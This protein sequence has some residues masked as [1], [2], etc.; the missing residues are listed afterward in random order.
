M[1]CWTIHL[2]V[3][4]KLNENYKL[5]KDRF[6]Y[7]SILPDVAST[8]VYGRD[9]SH[10]FGSKM[11]DACPEEVIVDI[12]KFKSVYQENL[13]KELILGYYVHMLT[14]YFY[15][16]YVFRNF[17]IKD[18]NDHI[19]GLRTKEGDLLIPNP[20]DTKGRRKYK[21]RDFVNYGK[22][23]LEN[24][25]IEIPTSL[26]EIK[27]ELDLLNNHFLGEEE[28]KERLDYLSS[29]EFIEFN[30]GYHDDLFVL[31]KKDEYQKLFDECVEFCRNE[32]KKYIKI[33]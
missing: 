24:G 21:Q 15:N 8:N 19:I 33:K 6:L 10:F 30:S 16:D 18:E 9:F 17:F 12:E 27:K 31:A 2:G 28:A 11:H 14:D 7:G 26:E 13:D 25:K 22:L 3:A 29:S 20:N 5:N 23:L 32:T 1:P 4:S